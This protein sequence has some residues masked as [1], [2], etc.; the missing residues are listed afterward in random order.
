MKKKFFIFTSFLTTVLLVLFFSIRPVQ[1]ANAT[2]GVANASTHGGG[3]YSECH[4]DTYWC[5][6]PHTW[7]GIC[8]NAGANSN[9]ACSCG[10]SAPCDDYGE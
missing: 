8:V 10:T 4:W 5:D 3:S 7:E 9:V 2:S 6:Y 1:E